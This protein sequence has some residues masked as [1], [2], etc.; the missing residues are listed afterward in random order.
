MY[1]SNKNVKHLRR[2]MP[3]ISIV[4]D[5]MYSLSPTFILLTLHN[6]IWNAAFL[7]MTSF[8]AGF[9]EFVFIVKHFVL[10][11]IYEKHAYK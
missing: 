6:F 8:L 7:V 1:K 4:T 9:D 5:V 3:F 2:W 11:V 10:D